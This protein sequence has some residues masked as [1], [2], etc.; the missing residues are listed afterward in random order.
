VTVAQKKK[1]PATR[2]SARSKKVGKVSPLKD[3]TEQEL[4]R[5]VGGSQLMNS[6]GPSIFLPKI[7]LR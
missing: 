7:R 1:K 3:L 4:A 5:V 2:E 6:E